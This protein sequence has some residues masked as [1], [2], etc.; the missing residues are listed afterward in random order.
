M[1]SKTHIN[2][3]EAYFEESKSKRLSNR[4][5]DIISYLKQF[6]QGTAREIMVGLG[7]S[8]P[9]EVRPR[10]T[11]LRQEGIIHETEKVIGWKGKKVSVFALK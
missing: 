7:L 1:E 3:L 8:E 11:E 6:K 4:Q 9:N 2:S 10:L 5:S